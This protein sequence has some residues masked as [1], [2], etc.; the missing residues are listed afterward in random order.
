MFENLY[1]GKEFSDRFGGLGE[2]VLKKL[3]LGKFRK[4]ILQLKNNPLKLTLCWIIKIRI[5]RLCIFEP[6]RS[7]SNNFATELRIIDFSGKN[8]YQLK[9]FFKCKIE[10]N[11]EKYFV[12]F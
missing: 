2:V 9:H 3:G 1:L 8:N 6:Q 4:K 10:L 12:F 5:L 11:I 7:M